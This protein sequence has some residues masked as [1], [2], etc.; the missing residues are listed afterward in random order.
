MLVTPQDAGAGS[1]P[2]VGRDARAGRGR[3]AGRR[4]EGRGSR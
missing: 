3:C 4:A 2:G 1:D